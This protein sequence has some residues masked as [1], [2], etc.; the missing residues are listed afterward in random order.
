MLEIL[1]GRI[2]V[3]YVDAAYCYQPSSV[4]CR[5]VCRTVCRSVTLVSPI[6][7]AEPIKMQFGLRN[8]VGPGNHAL[9]GSP[10]PHGRGQSWWKGRPF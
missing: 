9:D 5:S 3:Q 10:D 6:K 7:T 2:A 8:Q 4:V 1:L